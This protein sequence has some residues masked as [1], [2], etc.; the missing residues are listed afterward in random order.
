[1][2]LHAAELSF[3]HPDTKEKVLITANLQNEF[4]RMIGELGFQFK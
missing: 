1:M 2:M 4:I 3:Y